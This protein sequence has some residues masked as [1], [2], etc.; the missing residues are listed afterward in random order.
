MSE[1]EFTNNHYLRTVKAQ[2]NDEVTIYDQTKASLNFSYREASF[3]SYVEGYSDE[4]WLG[5]KILAIPQALW[6]AVMKTVVHL[7]LGIILGSLNALFDRE[8]KGKYFKAMLFSAVRDLQESFGRVVSLFHDAYGR[9]HVHEADF[10]KTCYLLSISHVDRTRFEQRAFLR[11]KPVNTDENVA[12]FQNELNEVDGEQFKKMAPKFTEGHL[13][14]VPNKHLNALNYNDEAVGNAFE[15]PILGWST[16][17]SLEDRR[18]LRER[19]EALSEENFKKLLPKLRAGQYSQIPVQ[20]F[21]LLNFSELPE[22]YLEFLFLCRERSGANHFHPDDINDAY[23]RMDVLT[24]E[25]FGHIASKLRDGQ[26]AAVPEKFLNMLNYSRVPQ[27]SFNLIFQ[28]GTP[29]VLDTQEKAR[30]FLFSRRFLVS[31]ETQS[32]LRELSDDVFEEVSRHFELPHFSCVREVQ[33]GL[34]NYEELSKKP[35][36]QYIVRELF[37]D[38]VDEREESHSKLNTLPFLNCLDL[39]VPHLTVNQ[40][41]W[42]LWE[43]WG[44]NDYARNKINE[45]YDGIQRN[46]IALIQEVDNGNLTAVDPLHFILRNFAMGG[47]VNEIFEEFQ[48]QAQTIEDVFNGHVGDLNRALEG[49]F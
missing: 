4:G 6:S 23:Q 47:A 37:P 41:D 14:Y 5:R 35:E 2:G 1:I 26:L 30:E 15:L 3:H 39:I 8:D 44:K 49:A 25:Q 45:V 24:E 31:A 46:E 20:F 10:H 11:E 28:R 16:Q 21:H 13:R 17:L 32:K 42:L 48:R 27:R 38:G 33:I 36:F 9:Y 34:L 7:A 19:M 18:I 40:L 12:Q 43:K 22:N 29:Q